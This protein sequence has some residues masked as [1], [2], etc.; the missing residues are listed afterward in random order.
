M[1][2]GVAA[3]V[4]EATPMLATPAAAAARKPRRGRQQPQAALAAWP[5]AMK[6]RVSMLFRRLGA[7]GVQSELLQPPVVH[8]RDE[9]GVLRRTGDGVG[10]VELALLASGNAQHPQDFAVQGHFVEPTRL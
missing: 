2:F 9:D 3:P 4:A 7:F 10:P 1:F 5:E 8:V 6:G